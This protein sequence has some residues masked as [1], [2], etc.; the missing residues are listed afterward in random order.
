MPH[1][2]RAEPTGF[3][4]RRMA[5]DHV[6]ASAYTFDIATQQ[7]HMQHILLQEGAMRTFPVRGRHIWPSE[8]DLM[9]RLAGEMDVERDVVAAEVGGRTDVVEM[10]VRREDRSRAPPLEIEQATDGVRRTASSRLTVPMT[11]VEY[12]SRGSRNERRTSD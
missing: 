7:V 1:R 6:L 3:V 9:A 11:F 8:M 12:V 2:D 10:P 5:D 4:L